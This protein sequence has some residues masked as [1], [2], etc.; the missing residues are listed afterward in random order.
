MTLNNLDH[1]NTQDGNSSKIITDKLWQY[2]EIWDHIPHCTVLGW[3]NF[4]NSI[5]PFLLLF[6]IFSFN[7]H[8][9]QDNYYATD[10]KILSSGVDTVQNLIGRGPRKIGWGGAPAGAPEATNFLRLGQVILQFE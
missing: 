6:L 10:L 1:R 5:N 4:E 8:S 7:L 3:T 2:F 9:L